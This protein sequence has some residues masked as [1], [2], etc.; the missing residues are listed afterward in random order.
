MYQ[1]N[2]DNVPMDTLPS[3]VK[4]G[5]SSD[6]G[7]I[8]MRSASKMINHESF[9]NNAFHMLQLN[10]FLTCYSTYGRDAVVFLLGV[11]IRLIS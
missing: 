9:V 8:G 10:T 11:M 1:G 2:I 6:M 4:I 7:Y 3:I 5:L